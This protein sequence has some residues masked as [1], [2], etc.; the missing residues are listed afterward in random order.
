[1][2]CGDM[3]RRGL[4]GPHRGDIRHPDIHA[5][6]LIAAFLL[7]RIALASSIPLSID[8]AYAVVVS[9]S[10]SLSYFD[11]PPLGFA[12]GRFMAD[13]FGCECQF[14]VRLL[15]L[16]GV[17]VGAPVVRLDPI[18]VRRSR[19]LLGDGLVHGR[20]ILPDFGG[21]IRRPRRPARLLLLASAC[22]AVPMM[23]GATPG[24][25]CFDGSW[26]E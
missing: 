21:P 20:A 1:M 18:R 24:L 12:V 13:I 17:P 26:P 23:L 11:H 10:H 22:L 15:R 5:V 25:H 16:A 2:S 8:E 6:F 3:L 19:S 7:L 14:V 9:R 4:P